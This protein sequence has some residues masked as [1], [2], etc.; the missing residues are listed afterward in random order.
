M[1]TSSNLRNVELSWA[2]RVR[3]G[4]RQTFEYAQ[5]N[6]VICRFKEPLLR[7]HIYSIRSSKNKVASYPNRGNGPPTRWPC[8]LY[9]EK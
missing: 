1:A 6:E 5:D 2:G 4:N 9:P 8:R 7:E 3:T